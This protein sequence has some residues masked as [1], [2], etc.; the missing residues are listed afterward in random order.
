MP[1]ENLNPKIPKMHE[2]TKIFVLIDNAN[3]YP[4]VDKKKDL[5]FY[6]GTYIILWEN[7]SKYIYHICF[8]HYISII[9]N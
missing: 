8:N 7:N 3:N 1:T 6:L 2:K 9:K 5:P 4:I